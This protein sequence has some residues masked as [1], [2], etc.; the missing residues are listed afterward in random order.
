[1]F[2]YFVSIFTVTKILS[3]LTSYL[4]SFILK[5]ACS[6]SLQVCLSTY[7]LLL[8]PGIKELCMKEITV[9]LSNQTYKSQLN[10]ILFF[11][12]VPPLIHVDS[13]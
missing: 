10:L 3:S 5:Q 11:F 2:T 13:P 4:T 8:T 1:M 9:H 6:Q 12:Q 7:D